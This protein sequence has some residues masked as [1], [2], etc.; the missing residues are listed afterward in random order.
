M[1]TEGNHANFTLKTIDVA[2]KEAT[3]A[4]TTTTQEAPAMKDQP[5]HHNITKDAATE[6]IVDAE[7]IAPN[8]KQEIPVA[9]ALTQEQIPEEPTKDEKLKN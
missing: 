8:I 6:I 2:T 9:V 1:T 4:P 3:I 7:K 5:H